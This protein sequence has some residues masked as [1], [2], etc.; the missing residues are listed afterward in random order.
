[1]ELDGPNRRNSGNWP[2]TLEC[3]KSD[4][5]PCWDNHP[6]LPEIAGHPH[7]CTGRPVCRHRHQ[8]QR[9]PRYAAQSPSPG[10]APPDGGMLRRLGPEQRSQMPQARGHHHAFNIDAAGNLR[11]QDGHQ[12]TQQAAEYRNEANSAFPK[13]ETSRRGKAW[14]SNPAPSSKP[15]AEAS[16]PAG[17]HQR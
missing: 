5:P 3:C 11:D 7:R 8:R 15:A 9:T 2:S 10:H 4:A 6:P 14:T 1:M 12:L 16:A 17:R 13:S